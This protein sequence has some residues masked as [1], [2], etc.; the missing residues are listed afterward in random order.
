MT[1][2]GLS[3]YN[4]DLFVTNLSQVRFGPIISVIY[5][6]LICHAIRDIFRQ[7]RDIL[8]NIKDELLDVV[9]LRFAVDIRKSVEVRLSIGCSV[10]L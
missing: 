4:N 8:E 6:T 9:F 3:I 1:F 2:F 10:T 5:Q 7:N